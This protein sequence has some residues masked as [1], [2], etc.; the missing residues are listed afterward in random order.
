MIPQNLVRDIIEIARIEEVV[1]EFVTIKK[2]GAN[3]VGLCPFHNEKTPS[4][5]VSPSKGIFKCF[6]CGKSGN[7]VGFIMDHERYSFAEAIRYLADKYH[8]EIEEKQPSADEIKDEH[9]RESL[10]NI[11]EFAANYFV[12][13]LLRSNE[14]KAVGLSYL[15]ERDFHVDTIRYFRVGYCSNSQ[16]A[17]TLHAMEKGYTLESLIKS[18][19]T[20]EKGTEVYDRFKG[21]IIFPISNMSGKVIA[22]GG[23]ALNSDSAVA[24]YINSP[25]T[26][27]YSKS[28]AL[29]GINL[30]K[31]FISSS[32][33][34]Y[35]VEGYTD[36]M[37]MV[38][39]GIKNVVGSSGTSLT[40]DQIR[41]IKRF[42]SN[43]TILYDGD[44]AGLKAAFRGIDIILEEGMNVRIVVFPSG[45]D[46]DSFARKHRPVEVINYIKT[47]S[48]DFIRLKTN[49]LSE[50]AKDDPIK[51]SA[52]VREIMNT[53]SLIPDIISRSEYV[54]ECASLLHISEDVLISELNRNLRQRF[55]KAYVLP[56][57][58]IRE[59]AEEKTSSKNEVIDTKPGY[60]YQERY[61]IRMLILY[62]SKSMPVEDINE[63]NRTEIVDVNIAKFIVNEL[64]TDGI[65]L[66]NIDHRVIFKMYESAVKNN[67]I[68]QENDLIYNTDERIRSIAF[69]IMSNRHILSHKWEHYRIY[70]KSEEEK[71]STA[72][73]NSIY[74]VK[75]SL[76][77]SIIQELQQE[78][79]SCTNEER[80]EELLL[81]I[82]NHKKKLNKINNELGRVIIP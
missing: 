65:V 80:K 49:L 61:L 50:E 60:E 64:I 35:L 1:S 27:I 4:F 43:V 45:E 67:K 18:G 28:K 24:K 56:E 41:L 55:R 36:V 22:F 31:A 30:A 37:T 29:Y 46:P 25:E 32:D 66:R 57:V 40:G 14:G 52:L 33:M 9:Q 74:L 20:I 34:C 78:L 15:S 77:Q 19:L 7:S 63:F 39:S 51:R 44:E 59:A 70:V 42:T 79:K 62:G 17:F 72:V 11:H 8:I 58:L 23:R 71:I 26:N 38:Q 76:L 13:N 73:M 47:F 5:H 54:K 68:I 53:V 69:E 81:L 16:K 75:V 2:R 10:F 48:R 21:R 12:D 82:Q 3:Y 6:G